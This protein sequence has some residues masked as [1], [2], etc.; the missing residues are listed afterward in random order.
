MPRLE[1]TVA[2]NILESLVEFTSSQLFRTQVSDFKLE[3]SREFF[4]FHESKSS[5]EYNVI[6]TEIYQMFESLLDRL[7]KLFADE[8]NVPISEIYR[9]CK[10]AGCRIFRSV[11]L[12]FI[13]ITISVVDNKFTPL[14]EENEHKWFVELVM[15]WLSFELFAEDMHR[16][17]QENVRIG[18]K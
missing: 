5:N 10:D 3:Y 17:A 13:F 15:S 1:E 7:F 16:I 12:F 9:Q 6:H 14:F 4:C 18:R 8:V 11:I 2:E